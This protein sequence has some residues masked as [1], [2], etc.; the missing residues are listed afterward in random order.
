MATPLSSAATVSAFS[1]LWSSTAIFA[2]L[3]AMAR[4]V[5]APSPEPPPVMRTATSFNCILVFSLGVFVFENH[6]G[7]STRR[8]AGSRFLL[9]DT[10][11]AAADQRFHML[12]VVAADIVSDR[13][14]ADRARHRVTTEKQV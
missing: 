6:E 5:A 12:D 3:A 2:P 1:L 9:L 10:Q 13:A 8:S 4:A 11:H 14:D 7:R